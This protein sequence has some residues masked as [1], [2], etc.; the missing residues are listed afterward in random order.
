[1][2]RDRF[3][4]TD[5]DSTWQI[6]GQFESWGLYE[7]THA[8]SPWN[9]SQSEYSLIWHISF[10]HINILGS[11]TAWNSSQVKT[12]TTRYLA[13]VY[14]HKPYQNENP[15]QQRSSKTRIVEAITYVFMAI[16]MSA[17]H[18]CESKVLIFIQLLRWFQGSAWH[19]YA[20]VATRFAEES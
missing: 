1:M 20:V 8:E 11:A 17:I 16:P 7:L 6:Q 13:P 5:L 9:R 12:K 10:V 18:G 14:S 15:H 19:K 4:W 2:D 3:P